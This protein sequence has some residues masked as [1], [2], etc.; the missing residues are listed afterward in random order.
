MFG[1]VM[2][3]IPSADTTEEHAALTKKSGCA[4]ILERRPARGAARPDVLALARTPQGPEYGGNTADE[5]TGS[6]DASRFVEDLGGIDTHKAAD[7]P[8]PDRIGYRAGRH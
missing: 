5:D 2:T 1:A 8:D 7:R 6:S 4:H 3:Q